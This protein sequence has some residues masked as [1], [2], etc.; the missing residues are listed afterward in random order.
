MKVINVKLVVKPGEQD[1]YEAFIDKLVQGSRA[2]AGNVSYDHF[3]KIGSETDYEIIEHWQDGAAVDFHNETPH[4]KAFLAGVG[5]FLTED[6]VITRM[7]Y[8]E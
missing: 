7:T 2:E 8:G 5:D 4:F 3:K 1:R 6:P